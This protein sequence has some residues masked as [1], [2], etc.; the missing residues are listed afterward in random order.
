MSDFTDITDEFADP[1]FIEV[2]KPFFDKYVAMRVHGYDPKQAFLSVFGAK[3]FGESQHGYR[4]IDAIESTQYYT[5]TFAEKL[6]QEPV[7]ELWCA[8]KAIHTLLA[9][10]RSP[11]VRDSTRLAAL[12]E[13]NVLVGIVVVDENGK[14]KAGRNLSDFY[15]SVPK[16]DANAEPESTT[17]K[18]P[19]E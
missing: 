3:H 4:R 2:N 9:N 8:K 19:E 16:V 13:L 10:V 7:A 12:K 5:Q 15:D 6:K 18:D 17:D 1:E 11:F 14:T